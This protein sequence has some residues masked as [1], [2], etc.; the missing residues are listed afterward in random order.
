M[1][2]VIT[3]VVIGVVVL[4]VAIVIYPRLRKRIEDWLDLLDH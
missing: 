1:E 2:K 4:L 3:V